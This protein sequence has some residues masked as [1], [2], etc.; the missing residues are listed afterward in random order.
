M[1]FKSDIAKSFFFNH[2]ISKL[3]YAGYQVKIEDFEKKLIRG[4]RTQDLSVSVT[5]L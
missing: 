4:N 5:N 1:P 3:A 2:L